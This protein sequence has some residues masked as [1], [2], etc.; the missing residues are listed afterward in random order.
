MKELV[1]LAIVGYFTIIN[2]LSF[3]LMGVDK[4]RAKSKGWRISESTFYMLSL[5]LGYYR[6]NSRINLLP[7]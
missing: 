6:Y 3:I 4:A 7:S 1:I 2:F 5:L